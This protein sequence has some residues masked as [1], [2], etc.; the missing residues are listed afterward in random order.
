VR[1]DLYDNMYDLVDSLTFKTRAIAPQMWPVLELTYTLFKSD[2]V[3]FL[4]E[5]LP[6]LD[7]FISFGTDVFRARA[8]Y[9]QMML[10]VYRTALTSTQLGEADRINGC[11]IAES[12]LLN[13][14]GH[15]DDILPAL[16]ST[17][18]DS[19]NAD[20]AQTGALRLATLEVLVN[21]VLYNAAPALRLMEQ[22]RVGAARA[23]IERW[24][25][26]VAHTNKDKL[27]RVHDKKL[28]LCA[29]CAL[30]ELEPG[31]VPD[32]LQAIVSNALKVFKGLPKAVAGALLPSA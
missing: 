2:A 27:P 22:H 30:M 28:T 31:Q 29:L 10:D 9:R 1:A 20:D 21:A 19:V 5:M 23:F 26:F 7:N 18:L 32:G 8:D 17:A 25:G 15:V 11:K 6:A 12:L 13:L 4:D 3:D 24:F 16:I 14:R